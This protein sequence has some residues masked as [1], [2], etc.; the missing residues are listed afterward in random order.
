MVDSSEIF[1]RIS[2][3]FVSKRMKI[4]PLHNL[5][6]HLGVVGGVGGN[7]SPKQLDDRAKVCTV[8]LWILRMHA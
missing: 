7:R 5:A 6:H 3:F 2:V 4:L 8:L 1:A